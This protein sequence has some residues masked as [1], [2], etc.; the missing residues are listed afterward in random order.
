MISPF[1]YPKRLFYKVAL[2]LA[3]ARTTPIGAAMPTMIMIKRIQR[4]APLG[5]SK[6]ACTDGF[7]IGKFAS[8]GITK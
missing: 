3:L 2:S 6:T 5:V 7:A 4:F 1:L 8:F